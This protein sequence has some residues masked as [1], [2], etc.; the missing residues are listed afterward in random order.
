MD[1]LFKNITRKRKN[2]EDDEN[3]Y[4]Y[5]FGNS[6]V[7]DDSIQIPIFAASSIVSRDVKSRKKREKKLKR[8]SNWWQE[9]YPNW[10]EKQLK[11]NLRINRAI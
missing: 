8:S 1:I 10:D 9:G 4:S 7:D 2:L 3:E 6:R 5:L 11:E